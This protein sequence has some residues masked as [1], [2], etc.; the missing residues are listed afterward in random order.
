M[1]EVRD[2]HL[3]RGKA[4]LIALCRK[5]TQHGH[6]PADVSREVHI[7]STTT[8]ASLERPDTV[9][10]QQLLANNKVDYK[11]EDDVDVV[12]LL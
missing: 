4:T 2:T 1:E 6:H 5:V 7:G 8:S 9:T 11:Y 12:G 10:S 3:Q